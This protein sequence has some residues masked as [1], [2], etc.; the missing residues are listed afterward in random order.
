MKISA[1]KTFQEL[2]EF[3]DFATIIYINESGKIIA[4]NNSAKTITGKN[5]KNVK[6]LI[7]N[8]VKRQ[9]QRVILEQARQVFT[10]V[11][12]HV[13]E[14]NIEVDMEVHAIPYG[15]E[16]IM[17]CFFAESYKMFYET[18]LSLLVPRLFYKDKDLKFVSGSRYFLLDTKLDLS[19][20]I[21]NEDFMNDVESRFVTEREREI[22]C[23]NQPEFNS[24]HTIK[25]RSG[26]DY[27]ARMY[28][29][30][31]IDGNGAVCGLLGIYIII[32]N[33]QESKKVFDS[34]LQE[35]HILNRILSQQKKYVV[36]WIMDKKWT[37]EYMSSNFVDFGYVLFDIYNGAVGW[38]LL[39]HSK[40]CD[41]IEKEINTYDNKVDSE[42]PVLHYRLR[43]N[44]GRYV[45]V[46]DITNSL[47]R[48]G[49]VIHREGMFRELPEEQWKD[50][51]Q[52]YGRGAGNENN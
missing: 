25:S 35:N 30:P 50:L 16:H 10:N 18:Y 12:I 3:I 15:R 43:K 40:D 45:W 1:Q 28:R 11:L 8:E 24:I 17:V 4:S 41:R 39:I 7:E 33:N 52:K 38:K 26:K 47:Q 36:R 29:M 6:E 19:S 2:V 14:N 9:F 51:E 13:G 48:E 34:V 32:L 31:V 21:V 49:Q 27:F 46:E 5:C 20:N 22:L 23:N 37:V 42:L 44:S